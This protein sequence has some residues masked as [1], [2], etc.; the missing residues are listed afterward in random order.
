MEN[1]SEKFK[2]FVDEWVEG[3]AE[4]HCEAYKDRYFGKSRVELEDDLWINH[5]TSGEVEFLKDKLGK[6]TEEEEEFYL[7][8]F[9][10][11]CLK[12][13]GYEEKMNKE[14]LLELLKDEDVQAE[15]INICMNSPNI[16]TTT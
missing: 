14:E 10:K 3:S 1:V 9:R 2:E 8:R 13:L 5:D 7:E 12:Y 4:S 15:V 6:I 16:N 11:E